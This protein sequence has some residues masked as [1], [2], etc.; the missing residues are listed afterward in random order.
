MSLDFTFLESDTHDACMKI[1]SYCGHTI[2]D[3]SVL[4]GQ[5]AEME[6]AKINN[7]HTILLT[8]ITEKKERRKLKLSAMAKT[9][10]FQIEPFQFMSELPKIFE[11]HFP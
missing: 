6:F 4:E 11:K 7:I 5:F 8:S 10:G 9:M 3:V 2:F 1:L